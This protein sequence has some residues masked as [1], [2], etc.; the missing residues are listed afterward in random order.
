M[1]VGMLHVIP[2]PIGNLGDVT[3]R[4][5]EL[6]PTLDLLL[7]E[8]TRTTSKLLQ[9][10]S[11][12]VKTSSFHQH[13]EHKVVDR[14]IDLLRSGQQIGLMSDAG[15]P[16]ISDPGFLLIRACAEEKIKI[17]VLPGAV[18]FV[19]ALVG[20]GLPCDRFFFEGFLPQKKG[21]QTRWKILSQMEETIVLY[22]SPHRIIKCLEEGLQYLGEERSI[23]VVREISKIYEEFVRGTMKEV[24]EEFNS[25]SKIKGEF[26]V[27]FGKK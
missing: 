2:G 18:A 6:I 26:V 3:R 19:P 10:F 7:C 16:G 5:V 4:A 15:M 24:L 27:I 9:H 20:S 17:T 8:D 25:R 12:S 21:R 1:S 14:Y 11:V 23:C 13:N 22:E